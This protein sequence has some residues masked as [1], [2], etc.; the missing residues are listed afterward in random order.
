LTPERN[1][2]LLD[3][4]AAYRIRVY[5]RLAAHWADSLGGMSIA[6]RRAPNRGTVTTLTGT[7]VDQASLMG[8]LTALYDM[9]FTLLDVERLREASA[10]READKRLAEAG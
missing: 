6:V 2:F 3:T 5:G 7:L 4:P 9:G 8:V 10:K 1:Y